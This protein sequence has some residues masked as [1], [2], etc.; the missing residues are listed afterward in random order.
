MAVAVDIDRKTLDRLPGPPS[1]R[2]ST[3]KASWPL[4]VFARTI[5]TATRSPAGTVTAPVPGREGQV[6][7]FLDTDGGGIGGTSA[8]LT[9][10]KE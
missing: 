2:P 6:E 3:R 1:I 7:Q 8:P 10:A 9:L 4:P 5:G